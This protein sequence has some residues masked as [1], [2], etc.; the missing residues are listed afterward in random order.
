MVLSRFLEFVQQECGGAEGG[1]PVL[2]AHNGKRF[3]TRFLIQECNRWQVAIPSDWQW[4][5]SLLLARECVKDS[6][7]ETVLRG[8]V[9]SCHF[10]H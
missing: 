4:L 5:D 7:G 3:D 9:G 1:I 6:P 2:I 8:L 10:D